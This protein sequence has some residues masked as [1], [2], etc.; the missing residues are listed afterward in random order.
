MKNVLII[1]YIMTIERY[2]SYAPDK[3]QRFI[4]THHV[5]QTGRKIY[6]IIKKVNA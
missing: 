6:F 1:E 5:E 4:I 3:D 2:L